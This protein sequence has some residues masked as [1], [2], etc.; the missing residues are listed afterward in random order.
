MSLFEVYK[1]EVVE[2]KQQKFIDTLLEFHHNTDYRTS[3][4][5]EYNIFTEVS[6]EEMYDLYSAVKAIIRTHIPGSRLWMQA[7]LNVHK[8]NECLD[9]HHHNFPYHGYI[10][11]DPKNT[12]T[13]FSKWKVMNA[14]GNI[15]FG[16]GGE[17]N[18]HRVVVK[19]AYDDYRITIGFDVHNISSAV[20]GQNK[21][22]PIL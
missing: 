13:E 9:W 4:F 8:Q 14:V 16:P 7:W 22:I 5:S 2:Q 15:Y 10:S 6:T 3:N 18:A 11:I 19:E 20:Q 17:A 21:F 12:T 1:A